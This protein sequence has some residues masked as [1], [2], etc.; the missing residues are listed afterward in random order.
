MLFALLPSCTF[1]IGCPAYRFWHDEKRFRSSGDLSLAQI[2]LFA[3]GG[4][5][6]G[7]NLK[8]APTQGAMGWQVPHRY[9]MSAVC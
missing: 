2:V 1:H 3:A 8:A 9:S 6:T 7:G 5:R 4:I